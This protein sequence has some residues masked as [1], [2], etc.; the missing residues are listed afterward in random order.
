MQL[1]N[2]QLF[3]GNTQ[4]G[5]YVMFVNNID[6]FNKQ[7]LVSNNLSNF[8][9]ESNMIQFDSLDEVLYQ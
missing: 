5:I 9:F 2:R 4:S 8:E 7:I 6:F 1:F 3:T